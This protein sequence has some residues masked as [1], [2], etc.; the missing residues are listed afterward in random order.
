[1]VHKLFCDMDVYEGTLHFDKMF[2]TRQDGSLSWSPNTLRSE[3]NSTTTTPY[4]ELDY[5][6]PDPSMRTEKQIIAENSNSILKIA[7]FV[8]LVIAW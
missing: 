1:M 2:G 7:T 8:V 6:F 5:V 3:T 4:C